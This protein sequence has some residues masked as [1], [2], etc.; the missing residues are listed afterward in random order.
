MDPNLLGDLL[1]QHAAA[2][3]LYAKQWCDA[4][5]DV[6]QEAFL[7]LAAERVVPRNPA[8]WLFRVVR[9]AP[10]MRARQRTVVVGTNRPRLP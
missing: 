8:A 9:S 6:V 1:D 2:L 10:S 3:E 5:E 4:P 7:R